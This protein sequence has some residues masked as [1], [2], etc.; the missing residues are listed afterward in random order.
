[1]CNQIKCDECR[2]LEKCGVSTL[3]DTLIVT[4]QKQLS[5]AT[6]KKERYEITQS[7]QRLGINQDT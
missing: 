1:M 5:T 3:K 2:N 4:L 7:L 6:T